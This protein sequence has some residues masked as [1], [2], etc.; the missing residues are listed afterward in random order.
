VPTLRSEHWSGASSLGDSLDLM[1][2]LPPSG[3]SVVNGRG[4]VL[5]GTGATR[6]IDFVASYDGTSPENLTFNGWA[7]RTLVWTRTSTRGDSVFG[8]VGFLGPSPVDTMTIR[9]TRRP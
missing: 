9:L 5:L 8:S 1:L 4:F 3:Q 2:N 7:A 6:F